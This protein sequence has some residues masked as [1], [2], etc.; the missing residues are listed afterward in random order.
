MPFSFHEIL[1][2]D[3]G[4]GF[5]ARDLITAAEC[6]VFERSASTRDPCKLPTGWAHFAHEVGILQNIDL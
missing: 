5:R 4:H 2:C 3:P 1:R 6:E